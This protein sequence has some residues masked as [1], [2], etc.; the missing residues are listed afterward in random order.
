MGPIKKSQT[1]WITSRI[2]GFDELDELDFE[3]D[4]ETHTSAHSSQIYIFLSYFEEKRT[5]TEREKCTGKFLNTH[6]HTYTHRR[7]HTYSFSK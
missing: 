5:I 6:T 1:N 3:L 7:T 4:S 2:I